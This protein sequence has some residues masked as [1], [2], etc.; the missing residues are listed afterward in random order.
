MM[1]R[2][3]VCT[4]TSSSNLI[5]IPM[6]HALAAA[7]ERRNVRVIAAR[8]MQF[9]IVA[10][11]AAADALTYSHSHG[12]SHYAMA[13]LALVQPSKRRIDGVALALA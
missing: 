11:A 7:N 10:A 9:I 12:S 2:T 6:H 1:E 5:Y 13:W 3:Y 4:Y 8:K